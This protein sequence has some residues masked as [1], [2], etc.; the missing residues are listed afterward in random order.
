M[1][2]KD[3]YI[4]SLF[5]LCF[6]VSISLIITGLIYLIT[7]VAIHGAIHVIVSLCVGLYGGLI[8]ILPI[9]SQRAEK[10]LSHLTIEKLIERL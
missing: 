3:K 6:I 9:W 4:K 7:P 10:K 2:R 8:Y 1:T 5:I